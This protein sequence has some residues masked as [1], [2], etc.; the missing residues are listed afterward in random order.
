VPRVLKTTPRAD[1]FRMPA[2]FEPHAGCWMLWPERPDTWRLGAKPAQRAIVAVAEAISRF[3]PVTMGVQRD[4]FRNARAMLPSHI[5]IVELSYNDAWIRDCGPTFATNGREVRAVDWMFNAWGGLLDGVYFPW[6]LDDLVAMKVAELE[7]V[8]RYRAP[9]VLEGGSI[10]VDGEGTLL[11]TEECLLNANRNPDLSRSEL[12]GLLSDYLGV[13]HIIWLKRGVCHDE[14][15][16]HVD[17][18]CCFIRPGVVALSWT[19]DRSDPQWDISRECL[20]ILHQA[21]DARERKLEV[22]PI[23][24]PG[25]TFITREE[26]EGVD[27]LEG[28]CPRVEGTRLPGSYINFYMANGGAIVPVYSD[29]NDAIALDVLRKLMPER[30][31]VGVPSRELLLGGGSIHCL[32][33]QQPR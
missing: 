28:N 15:N 9:F 23:P 24:Q 8:E 31:V 18:I 21:R 16:G 6:D 5:R 2:E 22:H 13:D 1:G 29:P 17:N 4:Q 33:Q 32:T 19:N 3:E 27:V 20:E 25:P 11:T 26:N 12:E 30:E 7:R 10:H 14:T